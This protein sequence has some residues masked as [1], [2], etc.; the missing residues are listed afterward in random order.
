MKEILFS[1][2][3]PTGG[4]H[5]GN[6]LGAISNWVRLQDK[7]ESFFCIVD[8]HAIT[9]PYDIKE[10]RKLIKDMFISILAC[11][12]DLNKSTLFIQS[13]VSE[14]TELAWILSC[15]TNYNWLTGMIQFKEKS[16]H[17]P[18]NINTGLL[19]YPILQTADITLYKAKYVPV[20]EDQ[21]QHI[22]LAR[23]IVRKFNYI[24]GDTLIEP[25]PIITESKRIMG[26]DAVNKM[27]KSLNNYIGITE[28]SEEIFS[29]LKTAVTDTARVRKTDPGDPQKCNVYISFHKNFSTQEDLMNIED[30]CKNAKIGCIDCKKILHKNMLNRLS[31]IREKYQEISKNK[32]IDDLIELGN[33]KAKEKAKNV[34]N[35]IKEKIGL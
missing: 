6:Y 34:L 31:P 14:H 5:I 2:I 18:E 12:I 8:Y 13:K 21:L 26:L 23:D 17:N 33:K 35:E 28:S 27:S 1:G 22:E 32:D 4:I 29:K 30:G 15:I 3:R 24:Y 10:L 25:K 9:T 11:G 20:G 16:S 7:Y 19:S